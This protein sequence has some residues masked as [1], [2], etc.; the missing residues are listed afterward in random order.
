M[1]ILLALLLALCCAP[2]EAASENSSPLQIM[3]FNVRFANPK[4]NDNFWGNRKEIAFDLLRRQ[5]PDVIGTQEALLS[6]IDD[7]LKALPE[8]DVV[9][10]GRNDGKTEGEHSAIFYRRDRLR[11]LRTGTFWFSDT[12]EVPGSTSFGNHLPRIC[13]W[14]DFLD[15]R[16]G[17]AFYVYNLHLDDQS[18][19]SREKSVQLL[20]E[21]IRKRN[22]V[23]PVIVTGDFNTGEE[24]PALRAMMAPNPSLRD[25]FRAL[26]PDET[27]VGTFNG[28]HGRSNGDKIDYIFATEDFKPLSAEI[29]RDNRNGR[30]PSDHFPIT[31][32]LLLQPS[33]H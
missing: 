3:S 25:T 20:L 29:L 15:K 4:D 31:A 6:Q 22:P 27:T 11:P 12:P 5:Q 14:A 26:H 2:L 16:T 8:Y 33:P 18:Q 9:A 10:V 21:T 24:N 7:L 30:Y 1:W 17:S 32:K 28:F 19:P 23:R 13:T